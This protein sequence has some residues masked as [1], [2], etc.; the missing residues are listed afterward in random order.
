MEST[1]SWNGGDSPL[2]WWDSNFTVHVVLLEMENENHLG[3]HMRIFFGED[4]WEVGNSLTLRKKGQFS[5][6]LS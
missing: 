6:F 1:Q 5:G 3:C 2:G 4:F